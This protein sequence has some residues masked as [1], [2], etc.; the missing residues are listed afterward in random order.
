MSEK[1]ITLIT[2]NLARKS[3]KN[4]S[5]G[6]DDYTILLYGVTVLYY[7]T[8]KTILLLVLSVALNILPY[9]LAFMTVYGG[10][11]HFARGLHLQ[12][13]AGCTIMGF[14]TYIAGI[15]ISIN[16][17]I[18]LLAAGIIYTACI[19]VNAIYAPSPT[20]NSPIRKENRLPLKIKTLAVMGGLFLT[21]LVI[22]DNAYRNII[23]TATIIETL[24]ILPIA[25]KIFK[26]KRD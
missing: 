3:K 10:L 9:T 17:N 22:G 5:P 23:L 4:Y 25:Y 2:D 8:I 14:V 20:E 7:F 21:M 24:Q 16:L 26:E 11:R 13:N 1:I 6:T 18:G 19:C 15:Y 12:S